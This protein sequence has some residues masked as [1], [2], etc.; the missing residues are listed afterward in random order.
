RLRVSNT[1]G[2]GVQIGT[3]SCVK[4]KGIRSSDWDVFVCQTQRDSEFRLGRLRV[5]NTKG[6]GVQIGTSSCVKHKGIRSSDWDVFVCQRQRDSEFKFGRL[7]VWF[8]VLRESTPEEKRFQRLL[9][10]LYSPVIR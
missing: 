6:F 10:Y 1:K 3:S 2:F 9:P 7:S 4:H 5:S 8:A